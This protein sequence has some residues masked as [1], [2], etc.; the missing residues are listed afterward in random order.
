MSLHP[1]ETGSAA[2][3]SAIVTAS[4]SLLLT[5]LMTCCYFYFAKVTIPAVAY[6]SLICVAEGQS[7]YHCRRRALRKIATRLPI[8]DLEQFRL[9]KRRRKFRVNVRWSLLS[10]YKVTYQKRL[11]YD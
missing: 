9:V 7:R 3:E 8:G 10:N 1:S 4:T 2:I 6:E 5:L 11:R